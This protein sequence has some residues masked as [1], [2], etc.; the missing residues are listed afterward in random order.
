MKK[1]CQNLKSYTRLY[2][3]T[4]IECSNSVTWTQQSLNCNSLNYAAFMQ[5]S[6]F[7]WFEENTCASSEQSTWL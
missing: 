2:R 3:E 1:L 5:V 4:Y 7:L 6:K